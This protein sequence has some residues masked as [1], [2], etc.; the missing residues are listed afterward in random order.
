MHVS[1]HIHDACIFL[2]CS[3]KILA[4]VPGIQQTI[5]KYMEVNNLKLHPMHFSLFT[6]QLTS[7]GFK[8]KLLNVF[9]GRAF[10]CILRIY[11]YWSMLI[12]L[13]PNNW[14]YVDNIQTKIFSKKFYLI[15][16]LLYLGIPNNASWDT[17]LLECI[18]ISVYWNEL[19]RITSLWMLF[20]CNMNI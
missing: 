19:T 7:R 17:V 3:V 4:V 10:V 15:N 6:G 8:E 16:N 1:S 2:F 18:M 20:E 11:I 14:A 9:R 13:A 5:A 12:R